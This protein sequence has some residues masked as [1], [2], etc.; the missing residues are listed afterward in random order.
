[1]AK[2]TRETRNTNSDIAALIN[3]SIAIAMPMLLMHYNAAMTNDDN[4]KGNRK[5]R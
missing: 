4:D 1:M 2:G 3:A 5:T